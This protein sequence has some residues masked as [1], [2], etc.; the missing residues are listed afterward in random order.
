M[1]PYITYYIKENMS[2]Y[3]TYYL[4]ENMSPYITDCIKEKHVALNNRLYKRKTCRPI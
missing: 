1:S 2:P 4:K 3:I